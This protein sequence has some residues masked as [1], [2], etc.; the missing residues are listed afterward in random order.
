[1]MVIRPSRTEDLAGVMDLVNQSGFG[2]TNLPK[3]RDIISKRIQA[4]VLAISPDLEEEKEASYLFVMEDLDSG[5]VVGT[6]GII[7]QVG[8][9]EPFYT[10]LI[11]THVRES[12]SLGVRK[13][14]QCLHLLI[15]RDGPCEIGALFVHPDYQK[16][17]HGRLMSLSRFLFLAE[18]PERFP[19]LVIAEM[20]GII[21]ERGRCP[22]WEA[23]GRAF[24]DIDFPKAD[25][26]TMKDKRFI[27]ELMPTHPVYAVFLSEEARSAIGQVHERTRPAL[28]LLQQE[29][30]VDSGMIDIF[31]GGPIVQCERE[32]IRT[33]KES[34]VR[35]YLGVGKPK[36]N[37]EPWLLAKGRLTEF[38][39]CI[40]PIIQEKERGVRL[41]S[42][43]AK[44]LGLEPGEEVRFARLRPGK[45][46]AR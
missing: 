26:L 44:A 33:V 30:F 2:L 36:G 35:T 42:P 28:K 31:D 18:H 14:M 12:A 19:S 20:R 10:Y 21:D 40:T 39:A 41:P 17:G 6:G 43:T 34:Q 1:M 4:S 9:G 3:D 46:G 27:A 38:R 37:A 16:H 13:E 45:G 22:F 8:V 11:E 25:Y 15:T 32:R 23:V 24:F 29:G 7:A 5:K